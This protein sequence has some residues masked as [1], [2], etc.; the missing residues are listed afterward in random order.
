MGVRAML[1]ER[2]RLCIPAEIRKELDFHEGDAVVVEPVRPGEFRV[3]RLANA[4]Q[5]GRGIFRQLRKDGESL[6]DE[7]IR[8]RKEEA[9]QEDARG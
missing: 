7:L 8:D 5:Q 9:K 6:V 2:G 4:I 1:D 3:L